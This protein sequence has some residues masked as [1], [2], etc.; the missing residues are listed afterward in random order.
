MNKPG[1][2]TGG[3]VESSRVVGVGSGENEMSCYRIHLERRVIGS[4][5]EPSQR[6]YNSTILILISKKFGNMLTSTV[7]VIQK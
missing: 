4:Y 7:F 2:G 3:H 1:G 6:T 5:V